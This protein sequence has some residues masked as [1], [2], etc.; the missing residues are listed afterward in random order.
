MTSC[1][2][3]QNPP[4]RSL[5]RRE[6]RKTTYFDHVVNRKYLWSSLVVDTRALVMLNNLEAVWSRLKYGV[7]RKSPPN[8]TSEKMKKYSTKIF[9]N[10]FENFSF[11]IGFYDPKYTHSICQPKFFNILLSPLS[12]AP[13]KSILRGEISYSASGK[14]FILFIGEK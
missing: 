5:R 8:K 12:R 2:N 6:K 4:T 11:C 14:K 13:I 3:H 1:M 7:R 10:F 9:E